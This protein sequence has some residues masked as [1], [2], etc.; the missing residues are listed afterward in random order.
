MPIGTRGGGKCLN[1]KADMRR[2]L[3]ERAGDRADHKTAGKHTRDLV[4]ALRL[5]AASKDGSEL[6]EHAHLRQRHNGIIGA[7]AKT[8]AHRSPYW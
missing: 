5:N 7:P 8:P 3:D 4:A 2:L 6:K 1:G